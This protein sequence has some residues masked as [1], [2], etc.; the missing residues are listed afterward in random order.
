MT[1]FN[2]NDIKAIESHGLTTEQVEHQI[3][4][5]KNG[6]PYAD[7]QAPATPQKG[8]VQLSKTDVDSLVKDYKSL[9][10]N[11]DII[12]FVPASGAASRMFKRLFAFSESFQG[13]SDDFEKLTG[14]Q[15]PESVFYFFDNLGKFSFYEELKN[16]IA[17]D[18]KDIGDLLAAKDYKTIVDYVLNDN[19][20]NYGS[21]PKGLILFHSYDD[22]QRLAFEEHIVEA[23]NYCLNENTVKLHFT[24]SPEHM[25]LF[26][27]DAEFLTKKYKK[28]Y[29]VEPQISFSV[30][31]SST[32][33]VAVNPDNTLFRDKANNPVFRP[34]GHGALIENLNDLDSGLIFIKNIDNVVPDRLKE[35]TYRYKKACGAMLLK[36]RNKAFK[37]LEL[38]DDADVTDEE[39]AEMYAFA[40]EKL[41]ISTNENFMQFNRIEKVDYLYNIL[42]RPIRICGMVKNEGEPGGG[43]FYVKNSEG[44]VSLQIVEGAQI[45]MSKAEQKEIL[46][47]STH[48]NPVD[49]ICCITNFRGERFNL[50]NFVDAKT[51]FISEKSKDGKPLKALELPG[52]WNGAMAEWITIFM[53]VPLI[54]FNPVK[55]V[56]DLLRDQHL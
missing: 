29:G 2:N 11:E 32:D 51:G 4:Q 34:A 44:R 9:I 54:T 56:N 10:L 20:L 40:T 55:E 35:E 33:T 27:K 12:K 16:I 39:I 30:Q 7:L 45:D 5:F 47:A 17:K 3:E 21:L 15:S 23:F 6:F 18:G 31:K 37:Y 42:N 43:P 14:D 19:G 50:K 46:A 13:T 22:E 36:L 52:L 8:I 41:M 1:T 24:V 48:F 28:L 25:V 53:E 49:L 26:E 38:L